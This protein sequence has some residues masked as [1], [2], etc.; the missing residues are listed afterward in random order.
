MSLIGAQGNR[1]AAN[2]SPKGGDS[3]NNLE[4]AN[5]YV[6]EKAFN[7]VKDEVQDFVKRNT[8]T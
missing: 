3:V 2:S 7:E 5:L 1:A 4:Y 8:I 6:E